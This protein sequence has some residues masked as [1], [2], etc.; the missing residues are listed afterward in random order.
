MIACAEWLGRDST[1][2]SRG[3]E[4]CVCAK[5]KPIRKE[6]EEW[7][8]SEITGCNGEWVERDDHG[9]YYEKDTRT[10]WKIWR[11][12]ALITASHYKSAA[13]DD[14]IVRC[15]NCGEEFQCKNEIKHE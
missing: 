12:S 2:C 8:C 9:E 14:V 15:Q 4:G 1:T 13:L 6:F 5:E 11:A 3:S 7:Y 10:A